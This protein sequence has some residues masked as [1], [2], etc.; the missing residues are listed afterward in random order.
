M[1]N[2]KVS[3]LLVLICSVGTFAAT[4][5]W[6]GAVSSDFIDSNNWSPAIDMTDDEGDNL[7]IGAA[8][9]YD[10]ICNDELAARPGSL[11]VTKDGRFTVTG[12]INYPYG[13]NT[14]NG[15]VTIKNGE[16][17]TRGEAYIGN[18]AQGT[19]TVDGGTF[20]SKYTMYIGRNS[21][22]S[23]TLN[24][25]EG[26]VWFPSRPV[27]SYNGGTG[28]I[29]IEEGGFC[30]IGGDDASWFQ[31]QADNGL[32]T[33]APGSAIVIDY[34]STMGRTRI[35]AEKITGAS[36]PAPWDQT[37]DAGITTLSWKPGTVA[38]SSRVYLGTDATAVANASTGSPEDL[39]STSAATMTIPFTLTNDI[40]Y[41]WRVDTTAPTGF[42]QGDVWS[43]T[44]VTAI[45]PRKMEKLDRGPIAARS[46]TS[47]YI[48]WRLFGTDPA[49]IGF[50]VYRGSVKLNTT[51]ITGS[52]N[53]RDTA[54]TA[55]D[56]Y[57]IRPVISGIEQS[58]SQS[59]SVQTNSFT[60][61]AFYTI[62]L[63]QI[64]GDAD[65]SYEANDAA[66]GDLDGDGVYEIIIKRFA[67]FAK[68]SV[69]HPVI[70]AYKL[71]GTF[72]WRINLGPNYL[73]GGHVDINPIVYDFDSDGF[74]EVAM[75]TCEGMT[76]G[77]GATTG[78]TNGDGITDY[79][80]FGG[81]D[82]ID[83]GPEFVSIFDGRTG[84]ELARTEYIPRVALS[85][86]GD[87]YGHRADKFH[88]VVAYLDGHKPS[89]VICRGIYG[90]TKMEG[91]NYRNGQ[92][93][94]LWHFTSEE[95]PG[96]DGQGNHNLTVGDVDSDGK[97]EI[98]YGGMCVDQ[99]GT[100]L[101]TTGLGHGDAIHMSD[102]DPD[103]PGLEVWRCVET[104][105]TGARL[106]DAATG[107][108]IVD[109]PNA[110]DTGRCCAAHIDSRYP[111]YQIWSYAID[112]TFNADG[113]QLSTIRC[114]NQNFL[115]WWDADLQR[116]LLDAVGSAGKNSILN[117]W[118]GSGV[119]RLLSLYNIPT[120]YSTASNNGSKGN[121]CLSGDLLGDWREEIILRSSDNTKLRIFTTTT[122]ASNRIYTLLHDPQYRLAI[123]WQ[124][125]G[126]NQ[127]PHPGF[128][129]GAGM[130]D[131]PLP[132]I[133]LVEENPDETTPPTPNPMGWAVKPY[134]NGNNAMAM[135]AITAIDASGVDYYFTCTAG[136]GH[137][138]GWQSTPY[139]EDTNLTEGVRYTYTVTARDRSN[140]Q[141]KT[142]ASVPASCRLPD[143][144]VVAA[145]DFEDGTAGQAFSDMAGGGSV[146]TV[147]GIVMYGYD[148]VVGPSFAAVSPTGTGLSAY[149]NGVQDGYTVDTAFNTWSPRTWTIEVSVR[150]DDISG[151]KTF[152]GRDGSTNGDLESDFY[153]QRN[154]DSSADVPGAFRINYET[155]SGQ[156]WMLDS[157]FAVQAGQWYRLAITS[158]GA[159]I[160]MYCDKLDGNG[161]QQVGAR[162][163]ASQ[164][165]AQNALAQNG[166]NWTFGR[167]WY[168][169]GSNN[170]V[171]HITGY[172]DNI[173]FSESVLSVDQFLG[174][175]V[176]SIPWLYGDFTGNYVVDLDDFAV[177]SQLWLWEDCD[178]LDDFD[179]GDDCVINLPEF[180]EM[181][182]HWLTVEQEM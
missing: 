146:G 56:V 14:F 97:D 161:Y 5:T 86:W 138:S 75:R 101:Y 89:L 110:G 119:T 45:K 20:T 11:N 28:R 98:V 82:Y 10:P 59:V 103:R 180:L 77:A 6:T 46:G 78:D 35:T 63:Q 162:D 172:L 169:T 19:V 30:Y 31:T 151:W 84:A 164:T 116:E 49:D 135:Q 53:Y 50:N 122:L 44:P 105:A 175:Q 79:R 112:G 173:R 154:N 136:G 134:A 109:H 123:A 143:V 153:L 74:A 160:T 163:I 61:G 25:L 88:M 171:D 168:N 130:S 118:N 157:N 176:G 99:D 158:D 23:G 120:A 7:T 133:E 39:G 178:S 144:S 1:V 4:G 129:I 52:T 124:C 72:L 81:F 32:I 18:G 128:Y 33:T 91:F 125:C 108:S 83:A 177:F 43:F 16:L 152:I 126:Y 159:A 100:G 170:F 102:M 73:G 141:N 15:N 55:T 41:Y 174:S 60:T 69:E 155:T 148:E 117:K 92:L 3:V 17:N 94:K 42:I 106:T 182:G 104:A 36:L 40:T 24:V 85:Q 68:D 181:A 145:W 71:D 113:T 13:N 26:I 137:D 34:Q 37:E 67:S 149:C 54:G 29:Y 47:N 167:G 12:G 115:L 132:N 156:R 58:A 93:Q 107:E 166:Y 57:S 121:P 76:D 38:T 62:P 27:I 65:G 147:D 179:L 9:G 127:P 95:N 165:P 70:E 8:S 64:P 111:G 48:G 22:G 96:Y 114:D 51:P 66:V 90:L 139:Y 140:N 80:S 142:I 87:N 150:L 21:G 131:P 2:S